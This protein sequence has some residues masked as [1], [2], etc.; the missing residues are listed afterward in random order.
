[1]PVMKCEPGCVCG[2]HERSG[3]RKCAEGCTCIK[4]RSHK[5]GCTCGVHSTNI[6]RR[7]RNQFSDRAPGLCH[8]C[9]EAD[10]SKF[11]TSVANGSRKTICKQCVHDRQFKKHWGLTYPEMLQ[12]FHEVCG[13][14][15]QPEK[16]LD[17]RTGTPHRLSVD[18]DH[19]CCEKGCPACFRGLL[20]RRCNYKLG[21]F[22]DELNW[23]KWAFGYL[24]VQHA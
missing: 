15:L 7:K 12:K 13:I 23:I 22:E 17:H 6:N 19:K 21:Q 16:I 2:K 10:P 14:C 24:G 11:K 1:M 5:P 3:P 8:E 9:G 4:H 20:C 18:H